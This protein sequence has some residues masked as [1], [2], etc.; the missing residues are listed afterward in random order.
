MSLLA[1][2][3]G[4]RRNVGDVTGGLERTNVEEASE[5]EVGQGREFPASET[6]HQGLGRDG[7]FIY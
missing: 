3:A 1:C 5:A 6:L 2:S 7:E 4:R